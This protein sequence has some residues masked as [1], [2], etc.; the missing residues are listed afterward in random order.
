MNDFAEVEQELKKLRPIRPS[1]E[2]ISRIEV[3]LATGGTTT[4]NV[5]RPA[6]FQVN[7]LGVGLGLAAAAAF[8]VL[9]RIDF[10]PSQKSTVASATPGPQL[11][12]AQLPN[13]QA[14]GLT[15]VVYSKRD[16][17]LIFPAGGQRPVRRLRTEKRETLHWRDAKTGAQLQVSYPTEE[18]TLVPISGQ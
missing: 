2:L 4:D 7:W 8:L 16:E 3:T 18:I 1:A 5:I 10:H 9:A 15:Q 13:Y 17:G 14:A 6:R 11:N 12:A